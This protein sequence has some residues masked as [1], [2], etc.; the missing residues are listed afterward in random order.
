MSAQS[1][2]IPDNRRA[3]TLSGEAKEKKLIYG[4]GGVKTS[5]P[6]GV[7]RAF[8]VAA[9][10]SLIPSGEPPQPWAITTRVRPVS[11][12]AF[13]DSNPSGRAVGLG[14]TALRRRLRLISFQIRFEIRLP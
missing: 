11:D 1:W 3:T 4:R 6:S 8:R 5:R 7:A 14:A 2:S 10:T 12:P 9:R 13:S